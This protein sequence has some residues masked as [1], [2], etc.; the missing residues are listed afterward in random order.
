MKKNIV[1]LGTLALTA[2]I[3]LSAYAKE[4]KAPEMKLD[5]MKFEPVDPKNPE[6]G[7][8]ISPLWGSHKKGNFGA[9]LKLAANS[10]V[11]LHTH[12]ST[13]RAVVIQGTIMNF[14]EGKETEAKALTAGSYWEQ[15]GKE[16]HVT[17]C[18]SAE[19]CIL[20]FT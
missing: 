14:A 7:P 18:A 19:D 2:S 17:K 13:Y 6:Q 4:K 9:L 10:T 12:T 15:P 16:K 8:K 11:P 5:E 20:F 3:A 1:L